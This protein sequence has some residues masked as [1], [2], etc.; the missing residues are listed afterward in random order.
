MTLVLRK[1][2]E[3]AGSHG[4]TTA[5]TRMR[6]AHSVLGLLRETLEDAWQA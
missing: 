4:L 5:I 6:F 1:Q 3:S 2:Q